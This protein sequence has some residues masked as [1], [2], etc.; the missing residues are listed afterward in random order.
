MMNHTKGRSSCREIRSGHS[1][2]LPQEVL[3]IWRDV[4]QGG[5]EVGF[6]RNKALSPHIYQ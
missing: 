1:R 2:I 4:V 3:K 6:S 5:E